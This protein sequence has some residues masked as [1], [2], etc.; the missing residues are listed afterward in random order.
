MII[1]FSLTSDVDTEAG[2]LQPVTLSPALQLAPALVTPAG[3]HLAPAVHC[4]IV[5]F[6]RYHFSYVIEL[7]PLGRDG[8]V[9]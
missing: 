2:L 7:L 6:S 9:N 4:N 3:V 5:L 8:G 1:V